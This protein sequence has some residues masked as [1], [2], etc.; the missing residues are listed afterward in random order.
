MGLGTQLGVEFVYM[1]DE[2][3]Q[4]LVSIKHSIDAL[5]CCMIVRQNYVYSS[6]IKYAS[7]CIIMRDMML[8]FHHPYVLYGLNELTHDTC[9]GVASIAR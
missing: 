7:K 1:K 9:H 3:L 2:S 6:H 4:N 5:R 8:N